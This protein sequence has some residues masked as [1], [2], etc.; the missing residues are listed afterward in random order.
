M[1]YKFCDCGNSGIYVY[2]I[3]DDCMVE[4]TLDNRTSLPLL[5]R[6][7]MPIETKTS[8][9]NKSSGQFSLESGFEH[10]K[11]QK[12]RLQR[13]KLVNMNDFMVGAI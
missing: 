12:T 6:T 5:S 3:P 11:E 1:V 8:V 4:T 13:V 9:Q 10:E 7:D 2:V